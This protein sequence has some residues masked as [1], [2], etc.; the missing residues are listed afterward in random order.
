MNNQRLMMSKEVVANG[1]L[2]DRNTV[3]NQQM[4]QK[5]QE[6]NDI[7]NSVA[8]S[9][10]MMM[11]RDAVPEN[12]QQARNNMQQ[13]IDE[14]ENISVPEKEIG[15]GVQ[16]VNN[17]GDTKSKENVADIIKQKQNAV[18]AQV[19]GVAGKQAEPI[20]QTVGNQ[21]SV[22]KPAEKQVQKTTPQATVQMQVI[23]IKSIVSLDDLVKRYIDVFKEHFGLDLSSSI[24]FENMRKLCEVNTKDPDKTLYF[25]ENTYR[26]STLLYLTSNLPILIVTS[27]I[28]EKNR[29]NILKYVTIEV[30]NGAKEYDDVKALRVKRWS[31]KYANMK[32]NDAMTI[33]PGVTTITSEL[34]VLMQKQFDDIC[35]KLKRF[36]KEMT[37]LV[38]GFD[39]ATKNDIIFIYSNWWYLLQGFENVVEM[40][41]YIMAIT[42]DTRRNLKL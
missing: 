12:V 6:E 30:E 23:N 22:T 5:Q 41:D 17:I 34:A 3:L 16:N 1:G 40:R 14:K 15:T 39:D 8:I 19:N 25:L 20:K 32:V 31:N 13:T 38:N 27:I 35:L 18:Q 42:D 4:L 29:K 28:A 37:N 21:K 7:Q 26:L 36:N 11:R 2:I 24:C 10:K 9:S 33:T